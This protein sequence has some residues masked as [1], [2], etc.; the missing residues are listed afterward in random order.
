MTFPRDHIGGQYQVE[1]FSPATVAIVASVMIITALA[2][3]SIIV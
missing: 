3:V 2:I 1:E